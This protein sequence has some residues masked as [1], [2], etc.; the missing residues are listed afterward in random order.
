MKVLIANRGEIACRILRTCRKLGYPT[1]AIHASD[2]PDCLHIR[3]ADQFF[4][5]PNY[6]YCFYHF[7]GD[8]ICLVNKNVLG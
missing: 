2:E 5:A 1:V 3:L 6:L 4:E 8:L 7:V